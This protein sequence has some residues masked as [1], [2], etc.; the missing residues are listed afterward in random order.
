MTRTKEKARRRAWGWT[1]LGS[2]LLLGA[3]GMIP[4]TF[5]SLQEQ[6]RIAEAPHW[7][8]TP[9]TVLS[10]TVEWRP[11]R[12][13]RDYFA[14]LRYT[15]VVDGIPR[16]SGVVGYSFNGGDFGR[17][18]AA[19]RTFAARYPVGSTVTVHYDPKDPASAMLFPGDGSTEM[20]MVVL[21]A[22]AGLAELGGALACFA[23]AK[24]RRRAR[25]S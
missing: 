9:G 12:Y 6:A 4:A 24:R 20:S 10:S 25:A 11:T 3:L 15:Y 16:S 8:A 7:P 5:V 21:I 19:A 1:L 22:V 23:V 2:V 18:A 14:R 17:D 13:H